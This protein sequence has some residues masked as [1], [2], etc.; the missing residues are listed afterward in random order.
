MDTLRVCVAAVLPIGFLALAYVI[1]S[2]RLLLITLPCASS[3]LLPP[4]TQL[5]G[6]GVGLSLVISF[7][8]MNFVALNYDVNT[9]TPSA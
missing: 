6:A 1:R 2:L 4:P 3:S 9:T 8:A 5:M 7:G